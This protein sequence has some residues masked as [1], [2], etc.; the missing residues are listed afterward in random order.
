MRKTLLAL[1]LACHGAA[2]WTASDDTIHD[3]VR[4]WLEDRDAALEAY[5][6]IGAWDT[7]QVTD[8]QNLF[9]ADPVSSWC[10]GETKRGAETFDD[11]I[12]AWD[13]S[14]VTT[15]MQMFRHAR[16]FNAPIGN[17]ETG[18]ARSLDRM[19]RYAEAFDQDISGWDVSRVTTMR[20]AFVHTKKFNADLSAWAVSDVTN[21]WGVFAIASNVVV[22]RQYTFE[23]RGLGQDAMQSSFSL[24]VH[25]RA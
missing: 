5:G 21:W 17:W 3:A 25:G 19:F 10:G 11:D 9:C 13:T 22:G 12:S 7:S 14:R 8:M 15:F 23:I 16:A 18:R 4:L 2:A 6:P 20:G 1:A 24:W